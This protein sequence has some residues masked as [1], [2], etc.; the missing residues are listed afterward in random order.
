MTVKFKTKIEKKEKSLVEVGVIMDFQE[1]EKNKPVALKAMKKD[2]K[3]DGFR[4]GKIPDDIAIKQLG[5]NAILQESANI[6]INNI[7]PD[8]LK[9]EKLKIIGYP[10]ISVTKLAE[11]NDF[12]FKIEMT[13]YPEVS[14]PDYKKIVVKIKKK[15]TKISEEDF[16]KAE[17]NILDVLNHQTEHKCKDEKCKESHQDEEKP[18]KKI[19]KL[20]DEIVK[21]F[22]PFKNVED[23]EKQV[24]ADLQKN[25][26]IENIEKHRGEM[27]EAILKEVQMVVP[28]ILVNAELDKMVAQMKDGALKHG[29]QWNDYLKN[30]KKSEIDLKEENRS[31][32]EKRT[33]LEIILKEIFRLEKMNLDQKIVDKQMDQIKKVHPDVEGENIKLYVENILINEEVIKFLESQAK[34]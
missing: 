30:L 27:M 21:T 8:I 20:T 32:G 7:F 23:F 12:E 19:T 24:K 3:V 14:L 13:V 11:G 6:T 28:E 29:L 33:K 25:K 15:V 22:G 17:K 4:D 34:K 2:A 9:K 31:E 1:V 10:A 26:D 16:K 18:K 5:E